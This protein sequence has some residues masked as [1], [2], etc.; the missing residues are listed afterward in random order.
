MT[1]IRL[2]KYLTLGISTTIKLQPINFP[3]KENP[4]RNLIGQK[5]YQ[6]CIPFSNG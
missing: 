4:K 6:A 1:T 3:I 5:L 2:F